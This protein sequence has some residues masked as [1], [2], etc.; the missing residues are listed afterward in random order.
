MKSFKRGFTLIELLVVI[1][2]IAILIALLLPAVQ[3]AREAARRTSCK[4]NLKQLGLAMH[5]Y[6]D[7]HLTLPISFGWGGY[8][9][10]NRG[11][12]WMFQILPQIEQQNLQDD[13]VNGQPLSNG[14][15]KAVAQTAVNAFLCPSDPGNNNGKLNGRANMPGGD[16]YGITNY[17][18]V[19]GSNWG[20]GS[21]QHSSPSGRYPNDKNGLDHGNGIICRGNAGEHAIVTK[22]KDIVDGT[23]HTYAI[24]E[25]IP[26]E[27]THTMWWW[28]NGSTGTC[29]IPLNHYHRNLPTN[30]GDWP[31]NYSFSSWHTGGGHFAMCDGTVQFVSENIDLQVYRNM[32]T[33]SGKELTP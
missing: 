29:S 23:S 16:Y 7:V 18:A 19:A 22:L 20:W 6:H 11:R 32:A 21:F 28:F 12:S 15:N 26:S 5:N 9:V 31:N 13:S 30:P 27:C 4:N 24:G 3:Q 25:A 14:S 2:I 17:K 1:A 8:D 10:N 33:I